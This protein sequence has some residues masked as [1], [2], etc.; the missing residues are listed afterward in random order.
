[1]SKEF[2]GLFAGFDLANEDSLRCLAVGVEYWR[3]GGREFDSVPH[4]IDLTKGQR[5]TVQ[6]VNYRMANNPLLTAIIDTFLK[7]PRAEGQGLLAAGRD[8][9]DYTNYAALE[10]KTQD[11]QMALKAWQDKV[12]MP[13]PGNRTVEEV[14]AIHQKSMDTQRMQKQITGRGEGGTEL[15]YRMYAEAS[16]CPLSCLMTSD[17]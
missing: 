6:M 3:D 13:L 9:R 17:Y 8:L 11:Y 2:S 4:L 1:M 14:E 15:M 5:S 12:P 7:V 16:T 10:P